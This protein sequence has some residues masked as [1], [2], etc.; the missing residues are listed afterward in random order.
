[1]HQVSSFYFIQQVGLWKRCKLPHQ[2]HGQSPAGKHFLAFWNSFSGRLQR[3]FLLVRR[4]NE[5][6]KVD[7]EEFSCYQS[8][9]V[10]KKKNTQVK[11]INMEAAQANMRGTFVAHCLR[12]SV[13][14][15]M[16]ARWL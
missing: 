2:D 4:S 12:M 15:L 13:K 16:V 5:K 10:T 1:M 14:C 11:L 9:L 3:L 8:T 7:V 6:K